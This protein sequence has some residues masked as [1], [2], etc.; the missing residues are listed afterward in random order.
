MI[1]I[2][3]CSY[4]FSIIIGYSYLFFR[5]KLHTNHFELD[6]S[7][8]ILILPVMC[9][10][11]GFRFESGIDYFP[12]KEL[13]RLGGFQST[14]FLFWLALDF[15][16]YFFNSYS[17]FI[18]L[19][20]LLVITGKLTYIKRNC[21]FFYF[22]VFIYVCISFIYVDMGLVRNSIS[23]LFFI[24]ALHDLKSRKWMSFF[25]FFVAAFFHHSVFMLAYIYITRVF[26]R[27][28]L[29]LF[30]VCAVCIALT[31]TIPTGLPLMLKTMPIPEYIQWK[32]NFYLTVT[33]YYNSNLNAYNIRFLFMSMLFIMHSHKIPDVKIKTLISIYVVGACLIIIGGFNIQIY[34]RLGLF[35]SFIEVLIVPTIV[36]S[37][38]S[39]CSR[40]FL[41]LSLVFMYSVLF[42]RTSYIMDIYQLRFM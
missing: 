40:F 36:F 25:W 14:E 1:F 18:F 24:F 35:V 15:H 12:Y 2:F 34:S 10:F 16:R 9:F 27:R 13:Y 11:S 17:S 3:F 30:L 42:V 38:K 33:D 39:F 23:L 19:V 37:N 29:L 8:L 21:N 41:C 32:L 22:S 26:S 6:L 20:S 28:I 4:I 7:F 5:D 31:N